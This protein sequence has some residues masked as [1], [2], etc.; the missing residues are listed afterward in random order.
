MTL[1]VVINRAWIYDW[2]RGMGY[3]PSVEMTQIR[4]DLGLTERGK[5]LFNAV[6]PELDD[7]D[8]FN[9]NCRSELDMEMAVLGCYKDGS[10]YVYDITDEELSGIRELTTAHEL[11]HAVWARMG[12][13]ER[14]ELSLVLAQVFET[15]QDLLEEELETYEM[16][17]RQEE[18]YV[19]AGTEV[20]NLPD[21]LEKHYAG[22]FE[23]QDA[24]VDFYESYI[25]VFRQIE[26]EMDALMGEIETMGVEIEEKTSEY[27]LRL[28]QLNAGITSFNSCAEV[29]GCFNNESEFYVRRRALVAEQGALMEMYSE[30]NNLVDRYNELVVE[31]NADVIH[32]QKLNSIV[33]SSDKPETVE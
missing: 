17:D 28:G 8:E 12:D 32:V 26:A 29:V 10:I 30:I 23:D 5:F 18:L 20:K 27:E 24:V 9:T 2:W 22:I 33:N 4:D 25:G 15:N 3:Q 13:G 16:G 31:Y 14:R 19:R 21:S 6:Q 1:V 7:R 11:L